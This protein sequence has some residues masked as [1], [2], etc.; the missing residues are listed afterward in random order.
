[1]DEKERYFLCVASI[2][3]NIGKEPDRERQTFTLGKTYP[4]V[5]E[6]KEDWILLNNNKEEHIIYNKKHYFTEVIKP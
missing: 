5:R 4:M 6:T 2:Y 1:M 3:C